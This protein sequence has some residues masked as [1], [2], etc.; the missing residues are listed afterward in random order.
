V[1]RVSAS[2]GNADEARSTVTTIVAAEPVPETE[3][4]EVEPESPVDGEVDGD[5]TTAA[6]RSGSGAAG[7][8]LLALLGC[9]LS[10]RVRLES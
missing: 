10:F 8:G 3:E 5:E 7:A 2:A 4:T 9:V 1:S 6:K